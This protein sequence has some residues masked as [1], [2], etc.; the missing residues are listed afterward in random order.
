MPAALRPELLPE[1]A[2]DVAAAVRPV[3][4]VR[5]VC[6]VDALSPLSLLFVVL[7][8]FGAALPIPGGDREPLVGVVPPRLSVCV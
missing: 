1:A 6:S 8:P 4:S 5:S 7:S 2:V 3:R